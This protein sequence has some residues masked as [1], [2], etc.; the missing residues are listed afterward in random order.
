MIQITNMKYLSLVLLVF[1]HISLFAQKDQLEIV[2]VGFYNLENLFDTVNSMDV[3]NVEKYKANSP[4]Y[5]TT[6]S[7]DQTTLDN[8]EEGKV[9]KMD[10]NAMADDAIIAWNVRDGEN[11]PEGERQ[12]TWELYQDKLNQLATV[13]AEMGTDY[14]P[15]GAAIIGIG[16]IE[17]AQVLEDLVKNSQIADRN[18]QVLQFNSMYQRG[19]DVA[20][21]Y[22]PK[23]FT[24]TNTEVIRLDNMYYDKK[25]QN[26]VLTR[27]MLMVQGDLLGEPV[28]FFVNHWPSRRAESAKRE[29]A[30]AAL[31]VVVDKMM[32]ENPFEK[33]FIMGDLNDDPTSPSVKKVV[34]AKKKINTVK[35]GEFYNPLWKDY[36]HGYGSLSYRGSWNLFD[37]ILISHG[38]IENPEALSFH[39]AEVHYKQY[40]MNR[41]GG[42]EG[43]PNR[44]FGGNHYQPNGFSD[45]LPTLLYLTRKAGIKKDS[46]KDGVWDDE[47]ECVDVPGLA[48]FNGCPDT[49]EDGITDAEDECPEV[50][51]TLEMKG[52][53][54]TDGDGIA[55]AMDDCPEEAG[56]QANN[57]CPEKD[58]DG[59]GVIDKEDECP[60]TAGLTTNNGCPEIEV[61]VQLVLQLAFENLEFETAKSIIKKSSDDELENLATILKENESMQLKISGHTDNVGTSESNM[62]LSKDRAEAV[63]ARMNS[64]GIDNGRLGAYWFGEDKPV[65]T[66]DN[67][68]G[69]QRNRRV[70]F[71]IFYK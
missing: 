32:A 46:D 65:A 39:S 49:D 63:K 3:L 67:A 5:V 44:S 40:L 29:E 68:E 61:E 27:D 41:S 48:E 7:K 38:L 4:D 1:M 70:E 31:M 60:E 37:Q 25:Q 43:G 57:G 58:S 62:K 30:A 21:L 24:P 56:L 71:E 64:L 20:F 17:N 10:I 53:P 23:Y 36:K 34:G 6:G 9:R 33:I 66:N 50:A 35:E 2:C 13:I 69:R 22:Q 16:E 8:A 42:Y 51:G 45:H 54:D 47:D 55:D 11:T 15:D 14:T 28:T 12:Y 52:C 19:I 26:K 59:D 18:Y